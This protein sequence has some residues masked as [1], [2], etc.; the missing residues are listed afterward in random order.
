MH[1]MYNQARLVSRFSAEVSVR[2]NDK[3]VKGRSLRRRPEVP[4]ER[5]HLELKLIVRNGINF[6]CL[7]CCT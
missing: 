3:R 4:D 6:R 7:S 2:T 5:A 1:A